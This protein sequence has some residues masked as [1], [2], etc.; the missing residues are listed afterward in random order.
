MQVIAD[1]DIAK[2]QADLALR[3]AAVLRGVVTPD[4][5][6][7][8]LA[9][10]RPALPLA[11][12]KVKTHNA[13]LVADD[14]EFAPNHPRN[15]KAQTTS[16]TLAYDLVP[17][18]ALRNLYL[19]PDLVDM[20]AKILGHE[21]LYPY[22]DPLAGLNVLLYEPGSELAWH[23]DNA[24]FVVTLML[25]PAEAGG[26]YQYFP[27]S[28][29]E[30]DEGFETVRKALAEDLEGVEILHQEPGDLVVF[31]GKHTL[32]RV[33]EVKGSKDRVIAV[34]S[35][36]PTPGKTLNEDTRRTFYGRAA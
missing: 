13:Y 18:G 28:R 26:E 31:Q 22:A 36:D 30:S 21:A 24:N 11:F 7:E 5:A 2:A 20:I 4:M 32:H 15:A 1:A 35:Y 19:S 9:E 10:V 8:M 23:F 3:G 16:A 12:S 6:Q 25:Q 14:P 17:D 27:F 34:F 33:S 29:S